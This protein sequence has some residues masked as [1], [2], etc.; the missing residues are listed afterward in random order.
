MDTGSISPCKLILQKMLEITNKGTPIILEEDFGGNTMTIS[1]KDQG[2]THVGV[3]DGNFDVLVN[4]LHDLLLE[5]RGL[6]WA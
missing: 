5:G 2:H 3:P 4:N 1:I 6:S